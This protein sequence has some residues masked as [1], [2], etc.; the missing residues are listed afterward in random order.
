RRPHR[1]ATIGDGV[2]SMTQ[3]HSHNTPTGTAPPPPRS[4]RQQA[5]GPNRHAW[6]PT[7]AAGAA[8]AGSSSGLTVVTSGSA[9]FGYVLLVVLLV[10]A[11]RLSLRHRRV[12]AVLVCLGQVTVLLLLLTSAFAEH[13]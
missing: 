2:A 4:P 6:L 9:W 11:V 3:Q 10:G 1:T 13:G 12:P 8:T 7:A 5:G